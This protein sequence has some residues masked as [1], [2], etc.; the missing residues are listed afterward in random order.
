[1]LGEES[2]V[3]A[4]MSALAHRGGGGTDRPRDTHP[5]IPGGRR[6]WLA[7]SIAAGILILA[8]TLQPAP[9]S[10]SAGAERQA[11][12]AQGSTCP[13]ARG[14][15]LSAINCLRRSHQLTPLAP[16][17]TLIVAAG[18]HA[19]EAARLQWWGPGKDPHTNPQTGST[20]TS[21]IQA[22][23]YCRNAVFSRHSE[24]TYFGSG[25]GGTQKAAVN[26]WLGSPSHRASMLDP[27]M[28]DMGFNSR[29]ASNGATY[30]VVTFGVCK[31]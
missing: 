10:A 12:A 25:S 7:G 21:R 14:G 31:R 17:T 19:S 4:P 6:S 8:G 26:W 22:A 9:A 24:I 16:N 27:G 30:Y 13:S 18:G 11:Q 20:I 23:G 29:T 15:M 1:M 5:M 28:R 2:C 3:V